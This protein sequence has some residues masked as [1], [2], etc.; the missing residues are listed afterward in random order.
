MN[1][2]IIF[3]IFERSNEKDRKITSK[4]N[5]KNSKNLNLKKYLNL[6]WTAFIRTTATTRLTT[7]AK[8]GT[9]EFLVL[10]EFFAEFLFQIIVPDLEARDDH[11]RIF[12]LLNIR[13]H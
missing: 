7:S 2:N 12:L 5:K 11:C 6:I 10:S 13:S 9:I 8:S 4:R 1:K 3:K